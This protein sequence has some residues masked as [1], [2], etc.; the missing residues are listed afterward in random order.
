VLA[1]LVVWL[2]QRRAGLLVV[3]TAVLLWNLYGWGLMPTLDPYSSASAL[4]QRVGQRIG[5]DAELGLVAWREQNL[6]QADRKAAVFGFK[7]PWDQQWQDAGPWLAQAPQTRWVLV[8]DEAMSPC[9]DRAQVIEIGSSNRNRWQLLPGTAWRSDCT[10]HLPS[11][12]ADPDT[13]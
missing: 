12:A 11:D 1:V 13:D 6:L 7:R 4:M 9:V 5:P 3:V 10:A 8:L 2:R